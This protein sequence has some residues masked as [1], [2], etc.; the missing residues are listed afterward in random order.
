MEL[1]YQDEKNELFIRL[2]CPQ[3]DWKRRIWLCAQSKGKIHRAFKS[4]Q[5]NQKGPLEKILTRKVV[6]VNGHHDVIGPP[7]HHQTLRSLRL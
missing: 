2:F 1:V 7:Q 3:I 5:E 6:L 4:R